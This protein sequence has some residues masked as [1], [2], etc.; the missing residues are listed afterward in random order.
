MTR[1]DDIY[2]EEF[3]ESRRAG[4]GPD[5]LFSATLLASLVLFTGLAVGVKHVKV[6]DLSAGTATVLQKMRV[7]F[8]LA[9]EEKKKP[10]PKPV[11]LTEKTKLNG[12]DNIEARPAV[13]PNAQPARAVYGL[14]RIFATGLGAGEGGGGSDRKSVV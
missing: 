7:S 10:A 1:R 8:N 4:R 6:T 9:P 11:D 2:L 5:T 12:K 14:R 13:D 3:A